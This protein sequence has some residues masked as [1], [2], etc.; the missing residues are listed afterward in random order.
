MDDIG[1]GLTG[2]SPIDDR[3]NAD[4]SSDPTTLVT[5]LLPTGSGGTTGGKQDV[6]APRPG[7]PR[8]VPSNATAAAAAA[9]TYTINH[10]KWR[11]PTVLAATV[12][13]ALGAALAAFLAWNA[14][15]RVRKR[16]RRL[17]LVRA[18]LER[19]QRELQMQQNQQ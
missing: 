6:A 16:R 11:V 2:E 5:S 10:E 7:A 8:P 13:V 1:A 9:A 17:L 4:A 15:R 19:N 14:W 18:Q 3:F 12:A